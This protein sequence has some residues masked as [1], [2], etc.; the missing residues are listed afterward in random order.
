MGLIA[1]VTGASRGAG[2]GIA[3]A[4]GATGA[5]VYVTGRTAVA[6]DSELPGSLATTAEQIN[7]RGGV[8]IPVI[9]DHADDEQVEAV[10]AQVAREQDRLDVLVHNAF[11]IPAGMTA[12]RPAGETRLEQR[13]VHT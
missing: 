2:K 1:V 12:R 11:A 4:L 8:G 6:G 5:T 9:C 7:A 3:L 10:F 13:I